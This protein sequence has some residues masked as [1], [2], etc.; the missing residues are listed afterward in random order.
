[1]MKYSIQPNKDKLSTSVP[2]TIEVNGIKPVVS[3]EGIGRIDLKGTEK[4]TAQIYFSLPGE[5]KITF[6]DGEL[7]KHE[8]LKVSQHEYLKFKYEFG[9]FTILFLL[10]MGGIILWTRKIMKNKTEAT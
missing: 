4:K 10:V 1:M 7:I 8:V 6:K 5:Y 2:I 3:I 9:A